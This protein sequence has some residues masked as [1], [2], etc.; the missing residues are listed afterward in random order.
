MLVKY[1]NR[2]VEIEYSGYRGE[3]MVEYGGYTD[4]ALEDLTDE[5]C[6]EVG[7]L[8]HEEIAQCLLESAIDQAHDRCDMER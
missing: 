7:E 2:E 8:Y 5:E 1:K 3:I 6:Y 4:G